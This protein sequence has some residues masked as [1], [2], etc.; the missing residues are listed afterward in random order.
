MELSVCAGVVQ[1]DALGAVVAAEA[2]AS[3]AHLFI[4]HQADLH[5]ST[6]RRV[7]LRRFTRHQADLLQFTQRRVDLHQST[8]HQAD[9]LHR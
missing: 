2:G 4:Q 3:A 5:Q 7:G 8:Q 1:A 9:L 6:Q